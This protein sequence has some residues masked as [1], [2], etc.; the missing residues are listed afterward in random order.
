[1][2]IRDQSLSPYFIKA[3]GES[4]DLYEEKEVQEGKRVGE[5]NE[6]SRGYF[7]S[8]ESALKRVAQLKTSESSD[9]ATIKQYI[10]TYK[11]VSGQLAGILQH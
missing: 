6:V 9:V 7:V 11:R 3:N 5:I 1:M 8:V 10:E 4:F 2:E